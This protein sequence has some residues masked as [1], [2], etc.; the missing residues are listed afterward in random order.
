MIFIKQNSTLTALQQSL[1]WSK[2]SLLML[3]QLSPLS[4]LGSFSPHNWGWKQAQTVTP[5]V[6]AEIG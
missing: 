5:N 4:Q 3:P 2:R 1:H 6:S